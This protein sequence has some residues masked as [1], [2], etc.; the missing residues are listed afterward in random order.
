MVTHY[1]FIVSVFI[2]D[3]FCSKYRTI[4]LS[5]SSRFSSKM[6]CFLFKCLFHL[7]RLLNVFFMVVEV[8]VR[9][10]LSP[11]NDSQKLTCHLFEKLEIDFMSK[12]FSQ[13]TNFTSS[14]SLIISCHVYV[15]MLNFV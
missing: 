2:G 13:I 15:F 7:I 3:L 4:L 11:R 8:E 9:F 5:S 6:D 10:L 12:L 14:S 1:K